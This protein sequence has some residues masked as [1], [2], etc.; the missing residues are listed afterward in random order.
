MTDETNKAK[1]ARIDERTIAIQTDITE[2][3]MH[4]IKLNG[5]VI[6][7]ETRLATVGAGVQEANNKA[8]DNRKNFNRLLIGLILALL[9]SSGAVLYGILTVW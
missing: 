2:V 5:Y 1:L 4:L 7:H 6:E 9:T 8:N 3:K